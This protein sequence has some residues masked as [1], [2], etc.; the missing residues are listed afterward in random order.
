VIEEGANYFLLDFGGAKIRE[1]KKDAIV[2]E[3]K[4]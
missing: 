3:K 4:K 1:K 2:E